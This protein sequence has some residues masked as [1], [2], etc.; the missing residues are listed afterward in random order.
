[1]DG[2]MD[3]QMRVSDRAGFPKSGARDDKP[4]A[5]GYRRVNAAAQRF[6][7]TAFMVRYLT[8]KGYSDPNP[9]SL[10]K[11]K[12]GQRFSARRDVLL[13]PNMRHRQ[14]GYFLLCV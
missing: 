12:A 11:Q 14:A 5:L 7:V 4:F 10:R 1:M 6:W 3:G 13:T 2:R 9:C 8:T